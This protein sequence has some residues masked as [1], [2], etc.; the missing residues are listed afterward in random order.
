MKDIILD[1]LNRISDLNE[2]RMLKKILSDVYENVVD[3]NMDKYTN[4]EKR[5][6]EEIDDPLGK[7]YIYSG[8]EKRSEIDLIS[9]FLHPMVDDDMKDISINMNE[10]IEKINVGE[11]VVLSSIFMQCDYLMFKE[12]VNKNHNYKGYI[13]T[14]KDIYEV[15]IFLKQSQKYRKEIE[16]LYHIF[17]LNSTSWNT[18]NCP[19]AYKF[20]DVV[21][22]STL[23]FKQGEKV[24]EIT[25]DLNE[26]EKYKVM[27]MVPLW[28]I[29]KISVQDKSF[30]MPAMD[31][32]NHEH[33]VSL[34]D[35]GTQNG[36]MVAFDNSDFIYAKRYEGDLVIISSYSEQ[37]NW[38]LIQIE[39]ISNRHKINDSYE[40]L[41]NKKTLGFIGKFAS[42]KSMV[43]RTKGEIARL[44][45]SYEISKDLLFEEVEIV[46]SYPNEE[47]TMDY[48]SFIDDNIRVNSYKKVLIIQFKP[49][50]REDFL[51][52]DK[53]SFLVSEIQL[54]FPEYRCIGELT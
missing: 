47:Q 45:K 48:N 35:I 25:V 7:F 41:S 44:L 50:N 28:N 5:I 54:L 13:K 4:L 36:Y 37:Q 10:M 53:M 46:D 32:I 31:R 6:Y 30:P 33:V 43:I 22:N 9:D 52:Q 14:D 27:D 16:Q 21:L 29:K 17:Q 40:Q 20:A 11:E 3:Y 49:M 39:D 26:Y 24:T 8:L 19:Y 12:I 38:N 2:R 34:A 42:L 18:V 1:R 15:N 51:I 23:S